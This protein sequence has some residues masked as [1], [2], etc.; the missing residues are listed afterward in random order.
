VMG[1]ILFFMVG[2]LLM[3]V[4]ALDVGRALR[5]LGWWPRSTS[6]TSASSTNPQTKTLRKAWCF[7]MVLGYSR[8]MIVRVV[9]DQKS[10]R[11][12]RCTWRRSRSWAASSRPSF[13][14]T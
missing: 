14:T 13:R 8:H 2:V 1:R 3:I 6:A 10:R 7:V 5:R 9:F 4:D 11:G 12:S